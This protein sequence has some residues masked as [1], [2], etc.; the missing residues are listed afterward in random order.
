M[1]QKVMRASIPLIGNAFA[2]FKMGRMRG[3]NG[4]VVVD[5]LE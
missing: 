4:T 2:L 1:A 3:R 5:G